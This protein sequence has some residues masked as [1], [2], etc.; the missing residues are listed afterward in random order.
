M[1]GLTTYTDTADR[2]GMLKMIASDCDEIQYKIN[3]IFGY[4]KNEYKYLLDLK[5]DCFD[6]PQC[7]AKRIRLSATGAKQRIYAYDIAIPEI[8][9]ACDTNGILHE[10]IKKGLKELSMEIYGEMDGG[11]GG[12]GSYCNA[13]SNGSYSHG[14]YSDSQW[15]PNN[16]THVT[17]SGCY[18][19]IPCTEKEI[20]QQEREE[21]ARK[22]IENRRIAIAKKSFTLA[23]LSTYQKEIMIDTLH[24]TLSAYNYKKGINNVTKGI[25]WLL[26]FF[27]FAILLNFGRILDII[28]SLAK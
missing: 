28:A 9:L 22:K 7:F 2:E 1:F 16:H 27:G 19:E 18:N 15:F 21:A 20:K 12:G 6:D 24:E 8:R 23:K 3:K 11:G 26:F 5:V 10:C 17:T 4:L 14:Y 25:K 13:I